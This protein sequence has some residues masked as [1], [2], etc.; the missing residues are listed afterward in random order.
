MDKAVLFFGR[1][2]RKGDFLLGIEALEESRRWLI[3]G[4]FLLSRELMESKGRHNFDG[5][6][7]PGQAKRVEG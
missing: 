5:R 4:P 3:R 7:N 1:D 6:N 2:A